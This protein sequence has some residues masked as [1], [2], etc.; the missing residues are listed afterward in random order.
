MD[1]KKYI[2]KNYLIYGLSIIFSRGFELIVLFIASLF[3]VKSQ[4]GQLEYYKKII[5]L[6]GSFLSLG[7]PTLIMTYPRSKKS[8][9]HLL[10]FSVFTILLLAVLLS[11]VLFYYKL[12]FLLIPILFYSFF[13]TGGVL[14]SYLLVQYD[15][16][17]VSIYKILVSLLFFSGVLFV[18]LKLND[19]AD[20]YVYPAYLLFPLFFI[21]VI[22]EIFYQQFRFNI[23][24]KYAKHFVKLLY[25]SFTL[26]LNNF[27]NLMFIY[28]DIFLI[29]YLSENAFKEIADYSF[30]L[31]VSNILLIIPLTLIQVDIEKL[32]TNYRIFNQLQRKILVL[33][34]VLSLVLLIVYFGMI[35]TVFVKYNNTFL[36]FIILL[37]A[38]IF[39]SSTVIYGASLIIKKKFNHTLFVNL[40][41]ILINIIAS[42]LLYSFFGLYGIAIASMLSLMIRLI[43]LRHYRV[44]FYLKT[45]K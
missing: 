13:F 25:G 1:I 40:L 31:N 44:K 7:F 16:Q 41:M 6:G 39:Q 37:I 35:H 42:Y 21:F 9:L 8:K 29:K 38:K 10:V 12:I 2:N 33:L 17:K 27:S 11:P 32:K 36:I 4:Y 28:T 23:F 22:K 43:L 18:V 5:E 34:G 15:S 26:L 30:A 14:Q 3:L 45:S 19:G 20:A 24:K